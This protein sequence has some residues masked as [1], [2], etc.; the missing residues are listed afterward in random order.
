MTKTN[1]EEPII[2]WDRLKDGKPIWRS[3][4]YRIGVLIDTALGTPPVDHLKKLFGWLSTKPMT[5]AQS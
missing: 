4:P 1:N 5:K 3:D 2:D